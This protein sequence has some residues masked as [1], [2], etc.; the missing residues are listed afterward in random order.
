ME[1]WGLNA[2]GPGTFGVLNVSLCASSAQLE[3][4]I[5][6]WNFSQTDCLDHADTFF[7]GFLLFLLGI[8]S[9]LLL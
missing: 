4:D 6:F 5:I 1:K 8:L 3:L 7:Y 9:K 2:V